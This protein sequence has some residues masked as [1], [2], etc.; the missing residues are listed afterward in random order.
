MRRHIFLCCSARPSTC[1]FGH[2]RGAPCALYV[3][4][5]DRRDTRGLGLLGLL[6]LETVGMETGILKD[7]TH[8]LPLNAVRSTKYTTRWNLPTLNGLL[9]K[10]CCCSTR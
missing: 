9:L 7:L 10:L 5:E 4:W 1:I 2:V 6:G 8:A 3:K